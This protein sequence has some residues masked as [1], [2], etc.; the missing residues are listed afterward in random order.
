MATNSTRV[1]NNPDVP[2]IISSAKFLINIALDLL[3]I[4]KIHVRTWRKYETVLP[5]L[6]IGSLSTGRTSFTG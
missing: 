2:L 4:S 3:L 1:L 6:M 5:L